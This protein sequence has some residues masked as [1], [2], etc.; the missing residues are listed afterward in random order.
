MKVML[1]G[2]LEKAGFMEHAGERAHDDDLYR[3]TQ[4]DLSLRY[5]HTLINSAF[6]I[7]DA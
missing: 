2:V 3:V 4:N 5:E 7:P 6:R 1:S